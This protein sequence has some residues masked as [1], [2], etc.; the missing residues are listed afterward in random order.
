MNGWLLVA[1]VVFGVCIGFAVGSRLSG[2]GR[3]CLARAGFLT[4]L[5]LSAA[6]FAWVGQRLD[7]LATI[8]VTAVALVAAYLLVA[9][10]KGLVEDNAPPT[11]AVREQILAYHAAAHLLYPPQPRG[12]R[13]FD[14][15]AASAGIVLTMPLWFVVGLL[16]WFDEPGPVFFTKN[17]VGRGGITF[18]EVKFR[19][20]Q[21]GAEQHTGPVIAAFADPRTLAV[22]RLIRRLHIDELPE[23]LNVLTGTMSVVG[24]RPLRAYVVLHA[25]QE[26]PGFAERHTIRPGIACIAQIEKAHV[27]PAERL[28]K[29][30]VYI[31]RMSLGFDL[32]LLVRAVVTTVRAEREPAPETRAATVA[33]EAIAQPLAQPLVQPFL[34]PERG[35]G[36]PSDH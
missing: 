8:G 7:G 13:A 19:S 24:P 30:L 3:D 25:L 27:E 28:E 1:S 17:S 34:Q 16:I 11:P 18:R 20:M 12:K 9:S 6:A 36:G 32:Q 15:I 22:G 29:D 2:R 21:H 26:V 10:E 33:P 4:A 5:G 31:H 14:I 35:D 23:L